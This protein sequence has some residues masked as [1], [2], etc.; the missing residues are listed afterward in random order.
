MKVL[1]ITRQLSTMYHPQMD[2]QME[3]GKKFLKTYLRCITSEH[4]KK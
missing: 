3:V 2:S 1:G 4:L